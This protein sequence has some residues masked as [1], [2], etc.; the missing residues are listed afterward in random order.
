MM[1]E[2]EP[3]AGMAHILEFDCRFGYS[4]VGRFVPR[5]GTLLRRCDNTALCLF[6]DSKGTPPSPSPSA[7]ISAGVTAGSDKNPY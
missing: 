5:F 7:R 4:Q 6:G 1:C 2:K 3:R